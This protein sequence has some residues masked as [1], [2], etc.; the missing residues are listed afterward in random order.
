MSKIKCSLCFRPSSRVSREDRRIER[1]IAL[2][3]LQGFSVLPIQLKRIVRFDTD[4]HDV[5]DKI[6]YLDKKRYSNGIILF[7]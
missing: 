6:D 2:S 5:E 7:Q 1:F 4:Y 3:L